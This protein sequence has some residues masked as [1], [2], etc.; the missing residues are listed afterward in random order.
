MLNLKRSQKLYRWVFGSD[1][2]RDLTFVSAGAKLMSNPQTCPICGVSI[3][4]DVVQFS[5]GDPGTRA[6][7]YARVCQYAKLRGCI[8]QDPEKIGTVGDGDSYAQMPQISRAN[9]S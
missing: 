6:R 8:N 5:N 9:N 7:L 4:R 1:L 3:T 2:T